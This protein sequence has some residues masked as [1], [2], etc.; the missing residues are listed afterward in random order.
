MLTGF[1]V[2]AARAGIRLTLSELSINTGISIATL[3]RMER[4][5]QFDY[6]CCNSKTIDKLNE[7]YRACGIEFSEENGLAINKP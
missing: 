4:V 5:G 1:Q 3:K 6:I 7:F 2:R